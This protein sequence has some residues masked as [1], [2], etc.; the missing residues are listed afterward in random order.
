LDGLVF[1]TDHATISNTQSTFSGSYTLA[2]SAGHPVKP[3]VTI[4]TEPPTVYAYRVLQKSNAGYVANGQTVAVSIVIKN[5]A[6]SGA[7][8]NLTMNDDWW[9]SY[10]G[11]L[12]LE[13]GSSTINVSSLAAGSTQSFTYVLKVN[14]S[15]AADIIVPKATVAYSYTLSGQVFRGE[16]TVNE[17]E[18]QVNNQGT[19]LSVYIVPNVTTGT[20]IGKSANYTVNISNAGSAPALNLTLGSFKQAT[21]VQG[22]SVTPF[23]IP[24][25]YS[26]LTRSNYTNT[27]TLTWRTSDGKAENLTTNSVSL[28]FSHSQMVIPFLHLTTSDTLS[29]AS[30]STRSMNVT[31]ALSDSGLA[32]ITSA[33]LNQS[34]PSGVVCSKAFSGN[35]TCGNGSFTVSGPRISITT[36][37]SHTS[38]IGLTFA[39]DNYIVPPAAAV[40][41]Y[42]GL[43]LHAWDASYVIP[44]GL[45]VT[46]SFSPQEAFPGMNATVAIG[47]A[48]KGSQPIYNLSVG[49]GPDVFDQLVAGAASSK[50][51]ADLG[52]GQSQSYSYGVTTTSAASGN[53]SASVVQSS[54]VFGGTSVSIAFSRG[55][56]VVYKPL[57]AQISY[58]PTSPVENHDFTVTV[59]ITNPSTVPLSSAVITLPVPD[60]VSVLNGSSPIANHKVSISF[61]SVPANSSQSISLLFRAS[62]GV[63]LDTSTSS[64]VYHYQNATLSGT[65]PSLKIAVSEDL[66]TRYVLPIV[67][68]GVIALAAL[69]YMRRRIGVP[70]GPT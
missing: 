51:F 40:T 12:Q 53:S 24:I 45:V 7:V 70:L 8:E 36:K 48:N 38:T 21:L 49:S 67:I 11:L 35:G 18:L 19:A 34:F 14:S 17:A 9:K 33:S 59:T 16:T 1:S 62:M 65:V 15:T 23:N 31:Y 52:A 4:V 68:A 27:F 57:Q 43:T 60:G 2:V 47:V 39:Q 54:M 42:R 5:S 28:V 3:N 29:A 13:N 69:V 50:T 25:N 30:L 26:S 37:A 44:A 46:K 64:L 63:T 66:T 61:S 55:W 41:T 58:K 22:T 6:T 32:N 56:M 10:P 20:P